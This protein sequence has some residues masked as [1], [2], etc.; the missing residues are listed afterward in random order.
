VK[1]LLKF[2][3]SPDKLV[4]GVQFGG[5]TFT[6]AD[7]NLHEIGSASKEIPQDDRII[8]YNVVWRVIYIQLSKQFKCLRNFYK[9]TLNS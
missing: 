3:A 5:W 4:L 8:G 7:R 2:G 1:Y 9:L 6:L